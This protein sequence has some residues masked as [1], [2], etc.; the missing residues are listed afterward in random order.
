MSPTLHHVVGTILDQNVPKL[1]I[2]TAGIEAAEQYNAFR[3]LFPEDGQRILVS[4]SIKAS[5]RE[6]TAQALKQVLSRLVILQDD[7]TYWPASPAFVASVL[8]PFEDA[9]VGA[10]S[11]DLQARHHAHPTCSFRG[12]WNFMGMAYLVRRS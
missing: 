2:A 10:V 1:I 9:H 12:F 4:H 7:H 5:R 3:A 11:A 8:A 6:Q